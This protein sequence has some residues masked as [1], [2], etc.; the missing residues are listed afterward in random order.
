MCGRLNIMDDDGVV[1]L[2]EQLGLDLGGYH[3]P[4]QGRF[5]RATDT[6]SIL[7]QTK[8]GLHLVPAT[9]W[10]LL[11]KHVEPDG[12]IRFTPSKYTSFN[13][14]YDKLNVPR[15]A[16]YKSFREKRCIIL[17]KGFGESQKTDTGMQ[18]TDFIAHPGECIALGGVYRVWQPGNVVSFSVITTPAHPK[19]APYHSKASPLMLEQSVASLSN[20]LDPH[21]QNV[22]QFE[23]LL[24]PHLPQDVIAQ[25]I[26]KPSRFQP[27]ASAVTIAKD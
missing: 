21:V 13:T 7:L 2:C 22:A 26:D 20:W 18:Y 4:H 24:T 8:R 16:G 19:L 10:L 3:N 11:D 14:R 15:S 6:V 25:P 5:I 9:W 23:P 17:V 1:A 12:E 27:V